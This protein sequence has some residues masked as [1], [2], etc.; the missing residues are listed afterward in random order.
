MLS[1]SE[2]TNYKSLEPC[3]LRE[4]LDNLEAILCHLT[5]KQREA[6]RM[7]IMQELLLRGRPC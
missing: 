3:A 7:F 1:E 5:G 6:H 2:K 4:R